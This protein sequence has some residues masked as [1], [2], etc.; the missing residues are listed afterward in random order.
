MSGT[1]SKEDVTRGHHAKR[2]PDIVRTLPD[3]ADPSTAGSPPAFVLLMRK[4][5]R[6]WPLSIAVLLLVIIILGALRTE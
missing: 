5:E 1:S 3:E 2:Q 6:A 4:L